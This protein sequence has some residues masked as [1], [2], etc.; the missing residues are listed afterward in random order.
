MKI[1]TFVPSSSFDKMQKATARVTPWMALSGLLLLC[2]PLF[3]IN[4]RDSHD[5]GD[6]YAQYI[7]QAIN[8]TEDKPQT[9]TAYLYD[10]ENAVLGPPAY[11]P[12]FPLML[13]PLYAYFG[14]NIKAFQYLI[15][16][17]L[18]LTGLLVFL[19]FRR[20]FSVVVSFLL[21]L[22]L[23]YNPWILNF[24]AEIM[25][26]IPFTFFF[27][28]LYLLY[29]RR[30]GLNSFW[31]WPGIG[32]LIAIIILLRPA[33]LVFIPAMVMHC[34]F[35]M[36]KLFR[37]RQSKQAWLTLAKYGLA[38]VPAAALFFIVNNLIFNI[39][40][41]ALASY[42]HIF[43]LQSPGDTARHNLAVYLEVIRSM[44]IL[45]NEDWAFVPVI[46]Q[47][48]FLGLSVIGFVKK[49]LTRPAFM[50]L[51]VAAYLTLLIIYP[52]EH[53]AMR[54]IIPLLPFLFYYCVVTARTLISPLQGKWRKLLIWVAGCCI[55]LTYKVSIEEM[56]RNRQRTLWGP[57]DPFAV[58][59]FEYIRTRLPED[60]VIAF[61]KPRVLALYTG[62]RS[63]HAGYQHGALRLAE[64][65]SARGVAYILLPKFPIEEHQEDPMKELVKKGST[66]MTW[67]FRNRKFILYEVH[68]PGAKIPAKYYTRSKS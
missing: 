18:S 68:H 63:C 7:R 66:E 3:M 52:Y 15:T 19:F 48:L 8:I 20:H 29:T 23:L 2:I 46:L 58:E 6:D 47:S 27:F 16:V 57:Q 36:G 59:V 42:G 1:D 55:L 34:I 31:W 4:I 54:F 39:P 51:L 50:E 25:A 17:I 41:T 43:S 26:D 11:Q 60:A 56:I 49:C 45:K 44:F 21:S 67:I 53:G 5:W 14:N 30:R 62:R 10:P 32:L 65:L 33:G 61:E 24:K 13:A 12:G 35:R 9:E 22:I 38:I 28:G 64:K 37:A 40:S